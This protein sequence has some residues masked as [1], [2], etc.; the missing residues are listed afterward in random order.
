M[1]FPPFLRS[2]GSGTRHARACS[3]FVLLG[4]CLLAPRPGQAQFFEAVDNEPAFIAVGLG[5]F[6]ALDDETAGQINFEY[7][8]NLRLWIFKP[9][10]GLF[11]STDG[12]V[13]GHGGFRVDIFFGNRFVLSPSTAVGL[14]GK[15]SGKDL[16]SALEFRSGVELA[17]RLD[18]RSRIGVGLFHL[19][20]ASIGNRN[21]GEESLL[22]YYALPVEQLFTHW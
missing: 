4:L 15:G 14:F 17:Y 1:F 3:F 10:G 12:A 5:A 2:F 20:N 7:R 13:Y 16:G 9:Y 21:P 19:S 22:L 8:S 6:D 11:V 18:D